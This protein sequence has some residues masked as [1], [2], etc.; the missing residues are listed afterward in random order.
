M[1]E[2]KPT[3][4]A[5]WSLL[6]SAGKNPRP[7]PHAAFHRKCVSLLTMARN[8]EA[9][10]N[11]MLTHICQDTMA[12][13]RKQ[14]SFCLIKDSGGPQGRAGWLENKGKLP[15]FAPYLDQRKNQDLA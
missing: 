12:A 13:Q 10:L 6:L 1:A 5:S 8:Q 11:R 7:A 14:I 4:R 2:S 3:K 9:I 15:R